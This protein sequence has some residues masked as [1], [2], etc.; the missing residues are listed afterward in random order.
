MRVVL[1]FVLVALY[2]GVCSGQNNGG[3]FNPNAD[4]WGWGNLASDN[5]GRLT[6]GVH[7]DPPTLAS[8]LTNFLWNLMGRDQVVVIT[9]KAFNPAT[10]TT[11][12]LQVAFVADG[13]NNFVDGNKFE[14]ELAISNYSKLVADLFRFR[15]KYESIV[16]YNE[17]DGIPGL[18]KNDTICN[19]YTIAGKNVIITQLNNTLIG[20]VTVVN[21]Q[22]QT[23]DGVFTIIAHIAGGNNA[24]AFLLN[25]HLVAA[26]SVKFDVV[27]NTVTAMKNLYAGNIQGNNGAAAVVCGNLSQIALVARVKSSQLIVTKTV[28]ITINANTTINTTT[29]TTTTT[30]VAP[31]VTT[32]ITVSQAVQFGN[33]STPLGFFTWSPTAIINH[34]ANLT[35]PIVIAPL[36]PLL[37]ADPDDVLDVNGD[38]DGIYGGDQLAQQEINQQA[39]FSFVFNRPATI[40]WDPEIGYAPIQTTTTGTTTGGAN[41][42]TNTVGNSATTNFA[43]LPFMTFLLF[44]ATLLARQM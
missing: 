20:N 28:N 38:P 37:A 36:L 25:N 12:N 41:G 22:A 6:D 39:Q 23:Q 7:G 14:L 17:V 31:T 26:T 43:N 16:T 13:H 11:E 19:K 30:A 35:A 34:N 4:W 42:N 3:A 33:N 18:T 8:R 44:A 27:I 40:N 5:S 10:N 24:Q 2:C 9:S 29:N 1:L 15:I 32:T 21:F